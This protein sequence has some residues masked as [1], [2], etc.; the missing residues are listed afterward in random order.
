MSNFG[1]GCLFVNRT[2]TFKTFQLRGERLW[3]ISKNILCKGL[4]YLKK[5]ALKNMVNAGRR[6]NPM[7]P[8]KRCE[9][10]KY[11]ILTHSILVPINIWP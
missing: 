4:W 6:L 1:V 8:P 7:T 11:N 5:R 9:F 10:E 2:V 3:I